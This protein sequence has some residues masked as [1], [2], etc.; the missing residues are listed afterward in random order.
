MVSR[1]VVVLGDVTVDL[2]LHALD[3]SL[4]RAAQVQRDPDIAGGG[5]AGNTAAALARLGVPVEFTGAVGDDAFG[6][7]PAADFDTLGVGRRGLVALDRSTAQVIALVDP[8]GERTLW[9]WPTDGGAL[10]Y[11]EA[12]AVPADL[13]VGAAWL[14]TTG[15]CL[16]DDPVR[17]AIHAGMAA[18]R[19]A[20]VRVSID[21]NLRI[22]LW[23]LT[24]EKRA[25]VE[26]AVALA[27]VVLGAGEE[28]LVP[29]AGTASVESALERLG[30]AERTV[31]ARM[32]AHGA[33]A[34]AP[35]GAFLRVPGF[36]VEARNAVG[37]GD[38]FNGGFVAAMVEGRPLTDALR[39]GNAV[40][41]LKVARPG[42]ARDLPTRSEVEAVLSRT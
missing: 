18:A 20:G 35:D 1:P 30:G 32:G 12:D 40:A 29:L 6:R 36:T 15:M 11:L 41:A 42:G 23:G 22:E 17:S 4:P 24:D 27:D 7:W 37:A 3:R 16:R 9:V 34:R 39:W 33:L 28:E 8:D 21:L 13:I 14:H 26:R 5:T 2:T 25:A 19:A 38:A 10:T 31:V